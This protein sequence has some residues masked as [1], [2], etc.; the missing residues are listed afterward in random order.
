MESLSPLLFVFVG[1]T[2]VVG[3]VQI[4]L[5]I[6]SNRQWDEPGIGS[7]SAFLVVLGTLLATAAVLR[8]ITDTFSSDIPYW[9]LVFVVLLPLMSVPWFLFSMR[10]TG[11]FTRLDGRRLFL[12]SAPIVPIAGSPILYMD[13]VS[14]DALWFFIGMIVQF[15]PFIYGFS[16]LFVGV[17][18]H[19][20]TAWSY[21]HIPIGQG[22]AITATPMMVY[23]TGTMANSLSANQD[24]GGLLAIGFLAA[25]GVTSLCTVL[26]ALFW[27]EMFDSTPAA[28]SIGRQEVTRQMDDLVV[29][30]DHRERV[31]E[32]NEALVEKLDVSEQERLGESIENLVGMDI[33]G[34]RASEELRLHT[35]QGH[36][37]FDAQVSEVTDQHDRWLGF[38]VTLHDVTQREIREQRLEVLNRILRHNLRNKL[39]VVKGQADMMVADEP[40]RQ[41]DE[42]AS[43]IT[44]A[45]DELLELSE[46]ARDV[47]KLMH[48]SKEESHPFS[49]EEVLQTVVQDVTRVRPDV[50][51]E[52]GIEEDL[53]VYADEGL[54]THILWNVVENAAVHNDASNPS[55][56]IDVTVHPERLHQVVVEVAD[57]GPGIPEAE[58]EVIREGRETDLDHASGL[59]LWA[60]SW[61]VRQLGGELAFEDND[62]RGTVVRVELPSVLFS[63]GERPP[64]PGVEQGDDEQRSVESEVVSPPRED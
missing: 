37:Q 24:F 31:I 18:V 11:R 46:R 28:G 1:L 59:G 5:G 32:V 47:E 3:V 64:Q 45:S 56:G 35:R 20:R 63:G 29:V 33:D 16:L 19:L 34:I 38:I 61:G 39:T 7:F 14:I 57:N 25:G 23:I 6:Y 43:E 48:A 22:V 4:G 50:E 62:P 10:H 40:P 41:V 49:L 21:A 9:N 52:L 58:L 51:I 8:P 60:T 55:V 30:T 36:R 54:L 15:V 27:Y 17:Y 53:T 44:A 13:V 26:V 2:G 12:V 42:I